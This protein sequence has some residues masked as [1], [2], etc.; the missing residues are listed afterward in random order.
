[1][2][3]VAEGLAA[4]AAGEE[5]PNPTLAAVAAWCAEPPGWTVLER[6]PFSS[7]RKWAAVRVDGAGTWALG[8]PEV[9][10]PPDAPA[11]RRATELA[12][13]GRRVLLVATGE[14]PLDGSDGGPPSGL[15]AA[16]L[17]V[18]EEQLRPDAAATL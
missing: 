3:R 7:A 4:L 18:L 10:L 17:V 6:V 14:G 11:R 2:A 8:A 16:G 1:G 13:G 12:A 15:H 9:L 5:H